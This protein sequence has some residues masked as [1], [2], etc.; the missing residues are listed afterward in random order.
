MEIFQD[1]LRGFVP[2]LVIFQL[3]IV[4]GLVLALIWFVIQRVKEN[5]QAA[6]AE[7]DANAAA[8]A[9]EGAVATVAADGTLAALGEPVLDAA[10]TA[11]GEPILPFSDGATASG[12]AAGTASA[13]ATPVA[14]PTAASPIATPII[15][16]PGREAVPA[17]MSG[18]GEELAAKE[19]ALKTATEE[20]TQLKDKIRYLESRLMEYEIVQEEISALSSL[21]VENEKLKEDLLK[22][23]GGRKPDAAPAGAPAGTPEQTA[24]VTADPSAGM[25]AEIAAAQGQIDSLLSK[26][27][28]LTPPKP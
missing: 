5:G 1:V 18:L 27:D 24:T 20:G 7:R 10:P 22:F 19:A 4:A 16:G 17:N 28:G 12:A 14:A 26:I 8:K 11:L 9:K 13:T 15:D 2:F 25:G 3:L 23:Q 6:I 21:R